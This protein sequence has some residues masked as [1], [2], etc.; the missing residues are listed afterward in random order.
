MFGL[1]Y[2]A[3]LTQSTRKEDGGVGLPYRLDLQFFA[4]EEKT[5][6]ATPRK[7]QRARQ[8]GQV[9][10][11][12]ELSTVVT[13]LTGFMVLRASGSY[14]LEK[15]FVCFQYGFSSD[16]LNT[17]LDEA[18]LAQ[19]F[20]STLLTVLGAFIPVGLAILTVGVLVNYLQTGGVFT[21]E[22]LK[23]KF[24]RLNPLAGLKRMFSPQKFIDLFKALFKIIG[25]FIIIWNTFKSQVFPLAETN[26]DYPPL[27]MAGLI[28]QLMFTIVLRIVLLLL[29]LAVFDFYYQRWQYRKSLRM[30]KKEVKDEIKQTEGD[31]LV[32]SRIRQKQRQ[33]AM[34][35][36]MQEVPKADVVITN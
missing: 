2:Y 18:N 33:L 5:E 6:E 36:M 23:V 9:P 7:R 10:R 13:L 24:D 8:R 15:L 26:V 30:T 11:S 22:P 3:F 31:P 14:L 25:V 12:S 21:L 32:R 19:L 27:E 20:N 34:R 35:R 1:S 28:W 4:D 29:A 16:R 17:Y